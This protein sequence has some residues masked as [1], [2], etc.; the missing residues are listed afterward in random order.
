MNFLKRFYKQEDVEMKDMKEMGQ[1]I[2]DNV[3]SFFKPV[4]IEEKNL[5]LSEEEQ[6]KK[7]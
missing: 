3:G 1:S 2:T 5:E 6:R 4:T 7:M